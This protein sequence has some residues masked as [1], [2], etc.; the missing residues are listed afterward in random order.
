MVPINF[1][2]YAT[3]WMFCNFIIFND[4]A[5]NIQLKG[6][7]FKN[8]YKNFLLKVIVLKKMLLNITVLPNIGCFFNKKIM[9]E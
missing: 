8:L 5:Y 2:F 7:S 9:G 1:G 3:V 4:N 6:I